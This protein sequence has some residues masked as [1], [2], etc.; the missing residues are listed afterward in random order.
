MLISALG[1]TCPLAE[2]Q[3]QRVLLR[4][5]P[6]QGT[7]GVCR[8]SPPLRASR[9]FPSNAPPPPQK[10]NQEAEGRPQPNVRTPRQQ[11]PSRTRK[12]T[13]S[14]S[15]RFDSFNSFLYFLSN[16]QTVDIP[17]LGF[18]QS[19]YFAYVYYKINIDMVDQKPI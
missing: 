10:V 4:L 16:F 13:R 2:G 6:R 3:L 5:D 11:R 9:Q 17:G 14:M 18:G 8:V 12:G 19:E 7:Q 1:S 15:F